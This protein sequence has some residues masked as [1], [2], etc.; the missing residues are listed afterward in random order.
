M[1][2][3]GVCLTC[4]R[5]ERGVDRKRTDWLGHIRRMYGLTEAAWKALVERHGGRCA[6][7]G[8]R[9]E[10]QIDHCHRTATVRGLLCRGC[11]LGLGNFR[12]DDGVERLR[13]AIAYIEASHA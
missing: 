11:N 10:L 5:Q 3:D 1:P 6:I 9:A 4:R 2:D 8:D 12:A 7:C 13:A